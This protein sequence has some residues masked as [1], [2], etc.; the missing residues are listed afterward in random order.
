MSVGLLESTGLLDL[1]YPEDRDA[2]VD[3][4][5]VLTG[6]GHF[7]EVQAGGEEA[8]FSQAQLDRL[9]VLGRSGIAE[10]RAL[11]KRRWA[12][13]GLSRND[14][15]QKTRFFTRL[16]LRLFGKRQS[17]PLEGRAKIARP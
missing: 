7:V 6:A 3:L 12:N 16:F 13:L 10:I 4:N 8:T 14:F 2:Q 17:K 15:G 9:L 1:N 11:Q 5:L